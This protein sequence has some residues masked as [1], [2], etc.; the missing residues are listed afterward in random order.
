MQFWTD[1]HE[2]D[3]ESHFFRF[4]S[5]IFVLRGQELL[6]K[7]KDFRFHMHA[8]DGRDKPMS[9][10]WKL[11]VSIFGI[12]VVLLLFSGTFIASIHQILCNPG[13]SKLPKR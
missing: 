5:Q 9:R 6:K 10:Q 11:S 12:I 7:G 1:L 4:A 13:E 2:R 3:S 8:K